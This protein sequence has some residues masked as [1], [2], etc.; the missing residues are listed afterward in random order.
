MQL[1]DGSTS[2]G[3]LVTDLWTP[4]SAFS[5]HPK[6]RPASSIFAD[7]SYQT[8]QN[9]NCKAFLIATQHAR[10]LAVEGHCVD[11][12]SCCISS[13][14][15]DILRKLSTDKRLFQTS[16]VLSYLHVA[17]VHARCT[18]GILRIRRLW[19]QSLA[20]FVIHLW[21]DMV[22]EFFFPTVYGCTG[23]NQ[24]ISTIGD[25]PTIYWHLTG[26]PRTADGLASEHQH[27]ILQGRRRQ[28]HANNKLSD[29]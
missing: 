20:R 5:V 1:D 23:C 7:R 9:F 14:A 6:W 24:P 17:H 21:Y 13:Q 3:R 22:S 4:N 11:H 26:L 27:L 19:F 2:A 28:L 29:S 12:S 10:A 16:C 15:L 18:S 8:T 25:F